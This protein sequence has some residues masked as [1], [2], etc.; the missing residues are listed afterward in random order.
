MIVRTC[1]NR[2]A[3]GVSRP[4]LLR[5]AIGAGC[6]SFFY[7]IFYRMIRHGAS[8]AVTARPVSGA[9]SQVSAPLRH[10]PTWAVT[11][12]SQL[13]TRRSQV[14]IL[15]PPPRNTSS[16]ALSARRRGPLCMPLVN[17]LSTARCRRRSSVSGCTRPCTDAAVGRCPRLR[18]FQDARAAERAPTAADERHRPA[19]VAGG[20]GSRTR[21]SAWSFGFVFR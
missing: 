4:P 19:G 9:K 14:Q 16:E 15:P 17:G 7:R 8:Q 3:Q 21:R 2:G 10:L 6:R 1:Q 5:S 20:C 11:P 13:I 18:L 12:T